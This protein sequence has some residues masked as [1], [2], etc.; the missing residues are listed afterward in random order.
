MLRSQGKLHSQQILGPWGFQVQ[1]C[2]R[3]VFIDGP[4]ATSSTRDF[5]VSVSLE[6]SQTS[7]GF[8]S[9]GDPLPT[10]KHSGTGH[11]R[12]CIQVIPGLGT[13]G[14]SLFRLLPTDAP[15]R[16][17]ELSGFTRSAPRSDLAL[18]E[19]PVSPDPSVCPVPPPLRPPG[20][21]FALPHVR[22]GRMDS[23]PAICSTV[24]K[25]TGWQG[26]GT[27]CPGAPSAPSR[28]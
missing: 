14:T 7:G 23:F 4:R 28:L 16:A 5:G 10:P 19:Q 26:Q 13:Q 25:G 3:E 1:L 12:S 11:A 6:L 20:D 21:A 2:H 9:V 27:S 18:L 24:S 8:G 17:T 15:Q 22:D